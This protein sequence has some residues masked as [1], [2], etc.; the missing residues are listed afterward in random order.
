M[1]TRKI[2]RQHRNMEKYTRFQ[3]RKKAHRKGIINVTSKNT[4][5]LTLKMLKTSL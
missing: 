4:A 1:A 3:Q 5:K 2:K